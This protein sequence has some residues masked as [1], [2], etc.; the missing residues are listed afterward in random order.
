MGQ[1]EIDEV[2]RSEQRTR[3]TRSATRC[4]RE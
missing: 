1:A 3:L 4:L 2:V